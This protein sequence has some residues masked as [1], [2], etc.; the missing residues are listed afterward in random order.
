MSEIFTVNLRREGE[1]LLR[2]N[3]HHNE[4]HWRKSGTGAAKME[5]LKGW[6]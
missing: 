6:E 3:F 4:E 1:A 5:L 2:N